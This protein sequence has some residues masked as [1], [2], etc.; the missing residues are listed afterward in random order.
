[1]C[2]LL[3]MN[4]NVPTDICFSFD[5]FR[6]RGGLTDVHKD[7][8]GIAFFEGA[9]CR[10][11]LDVEASAKSPVADLVHSYPI[12]STNVIAHI[13]KATQGRV[14]LENTHPFQREL[15]GRYWLFAHNGNLLDFAPPSGTRYRRVGSTD[16]ELAFCFLLQTLCDRF[17]GVMPPRTELFEAIVEIA[18]QIGKHGEFN[19]LLSNGDS[20]FAHCGSKLCYV[21]RQAPFTTAHL[22]DQDVSVDFSEVTSPDDRV[23][24]IATQALT[25]NES[26][27]TIAPGT[28]MLFHDRLPI[29]SASTAIAV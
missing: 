24:V 27:T 13:R 20:L 21:V 6:I 17:P 23:A 7:G 22:A 5:G 1:M 26:W 9:G 3:G 10:V 12:H 11:F 19:F 2:Q 16:S 29:D 15:W 25:D 28:L 14:A 8:W 18:G 4:C